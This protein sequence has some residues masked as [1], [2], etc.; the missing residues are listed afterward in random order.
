MGGGFFTVGD[1]V[2]E[3]DVEG[4]VCVRGEGV[5]VFADYVL[6]FAVFV[7]HCVFNLTKRKLCVSEWFYAPPGHP[8]LFVYVNGLLLTCMFNCC[9]SPRIPSTIAVTTTNWSFCTK[10]RMHRSYLC[11]S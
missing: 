3:A 5:S 4:A 9:P 11:D 10:L 2:L 7:S 1:H 8:L 6:G